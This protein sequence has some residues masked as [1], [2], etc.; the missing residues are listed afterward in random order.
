M[1]DLLQEITIYHGKS[2]TRYNVKA[3]VRC[4]SYKNRNTT[5]SN[6]T[7]NALI[8]CFD[9]LGYKTTWD[10]TKG[11]IIV[12]KQV[13]DSITKAPLTELREKYGKEAVLEV[14]SIDEFIFDDED[15]KELNHIKIGGR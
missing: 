8:R 9:V 11:D 6:I 13:S 4:T 12:L 3:S 7:D 15:I 5:G 2:F 1:E 14:S 10:C